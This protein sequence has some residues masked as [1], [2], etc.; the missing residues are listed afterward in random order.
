MCEDS[1]NG[2]SGRS[3]AQYPRGKSTIVHDDPGVGVANE[4][5]HH[6]GKS[7]LPTCLEYPLKTWLVTGGTQSPS[8]QTNAKPRARQLKDLAR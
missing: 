1:C 4:V 2:F 7:D 8:K 5:P 6:M 3:A